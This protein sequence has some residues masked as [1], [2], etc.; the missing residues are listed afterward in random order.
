MPSRRKL[1]AY[2]APMVLFVVLLS[3]I[4]ALKKTDHHFWLSSCEYWVYPLQ[5]ILC[6]GLLIWFRREY[7][8]HRPARIGFVVFVGVIVFIIWISPEQFFGFSA[9]TSGF[10]PDVFTGQPALY[11]PTIVFRLLRLVVVVPLVEE[12]FWRGFLLRF[13]INENFDRVPFGTF[14]WISFV[15]VTGLFGFSHAAEDWIAALITGAIYNGVAYR[16]KSLF[17]CILVHAITNLLL[18][19]WILQT[20]Q[21]GFW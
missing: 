16:T 19:V 13:L 10:N 8:F 18:G 1:I 12:I 21:W 11:W 2:V 9:R 5:T 4:A 7:D 17:S 14:S 3:M 15:V 6:G 20:K